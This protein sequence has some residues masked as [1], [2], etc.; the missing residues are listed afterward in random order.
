MSDASQPALTPARRPRWRRWLRNA[1]IVLASLLALV[2]MTLMAI[3]WIPGLSRIVL[4]RALTGWD[5]SIPARVEWDG[6]A[7][8]LAGGVRI[9]GLRVWDS[10]DQALVEVGEAM[11]VVDL[12]ALI[13]G[14]VRVD[15]LALRD[16]VVHV[17]HRWGDLSNP[18][19][20]PSPP[21]PGYGPD[22]PLRIVAAVELG[23]LRVV[24]DG[25]DLL[26]LDRLGLELTGEGR[27]ATADL[28]LRNI[29]LPSADLIVDAVDLRAAWAEPRLTI[30]RLD[31][32]MSLASVR[33]PGPT[34]LD[35]S[36]LEFALGLTL[37]ANPRAVAERIELAQRL[38]GGRMPE[39]LGVALRGQGRLDAPVLDL[40]VDLGRDGRLH[41]EGYA[42]R[43]AETDEAQVRVA[44]DARVAAGLVNPDQP[45]LRLALAGDAA[46]AVDGGL[47]ASLGL[48]LA[49]RGSGERVA[50]RASGSLAHAPER[51]G[52][53]ELVDL[54]G[55]A[56]L[57]LRGAGVLVDGQLTLGA[58]PSGTL[59]VSIPELG[60]PLG[61]VSDLLGVTSLRQVQGRVELSGSCARSTNPDAPDQVLRCPA[62][63]EL[64]RFAGFGVSLSTAR[65]DATLEPLRDEPWFDA[66]LHAGGLRLAAAPIV[67]SELDAHVVGTPKAL[68]VRASGQGP[69]DRFEIAA[70][71]REVDGRHR[72]ELETLSLT[73][74][75]GGAPM[76]LGATHPSAV[77]LG[78]D[79]IDLEDV[80]LEL[81]GAQNR[82]RRLD[83]PDRER[84]QRRPPDRDPARS[85]SARP[86]DPRSALVRDHRA[87]R[88]GARAPHRPAWRGRVSR[89][90]ARAR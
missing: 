61:L 14:E 45:E 11:L 28:Q 79:R 42:K 49:E 62:E 4:E 83:R 65:L 64:D 87:R 85:G 26:A 32:D 84:P 53:A 10:E 54:A 37:D 9:E 57:E 74:T 89:P 24:D 18:D 13:S 86:V 20:E 22:L 71:L 17:D 51:W 70:K 21:S 44:L 80:A 55:E 72:I 23:N 78:D 35:V 43:D 46:R 1:G 66:N 52:L 27:E 40:S 15:G 50:L 6:I 67:L 39:Q 81:E 29:A 34:W 19:A 38:P 56:A 16:V 68:E 41:L 75:R 30:E 59:V 7:G 2:V 25:G 63:L 88:S 33:L 36:T 60:R 8:T 48:D 47:T 69:E 90:Q 31:V 5:D 82:R 76:T 3:L 73:T 77:I 58:D 12:G